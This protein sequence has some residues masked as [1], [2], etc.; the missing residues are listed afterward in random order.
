MLTDPKLVQSALLCRQGCYVLAFCFGWD[1]L[2]L[3]QAEKLHLQ[4]PVYVLLGLFKKQPFQAGTQVPVYVLLGLFT[5]V[6]KTIMGYSGRCYFSNRSAHS[7][8]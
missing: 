1:Y 8:V 2:L 7:A 3:D 4:V 6:G 5:I